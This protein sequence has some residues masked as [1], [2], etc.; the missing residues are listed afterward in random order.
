[1]RDAIQIALDALLGKPVWKCTRAADMACFQFGARR[2]K[3]TKRVLIEVGE[4]ALHLQ[5]PWRIVK[6][7]QIVMAALDVY[8]PRRN[9]E[10]AGSPDFD[11][12]HESNLLEHRSQEFFQNGATEYLV[13]EV[14]AGNAG[15]VRIALEKGFWLEIF[16]AD[17][18]NE[19]QWRF[20]QPTSEEGLATTE[21]THLVVA[22]DTATIE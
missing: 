13:Q 22:G 3:T 5:C 19:E 14:V 8:H 6:D 18:R 9:D 2:S 11:W 1:M 4:Y 10:G 20:F 21:G 15:A 7:D 12:E 17:S 16:P